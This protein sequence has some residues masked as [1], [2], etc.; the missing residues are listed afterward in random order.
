[1]A[2]LRLCCTACMRRGVEVVVETEGLEVTLIDFTLSRL[3]TPAGELQFSDLAADPWLF[4]QDRSIQVGEALG[5]FLQLYCL[6]S[7][8]ECC[9]LCGTCMH[10]SAMSGVPMCVIRPEKDI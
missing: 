3:R 5:T 8:R 6:I 2:Q 4:T 9:G 10:S 1:M 7:A